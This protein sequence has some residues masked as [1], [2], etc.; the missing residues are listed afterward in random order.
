[1]FI[2]QVAGA[3]MG[4]PNLAFPW[5]RIAHLLCPITIL[6]LSYSSHRHSIAMN[7]GESDY[8]LHD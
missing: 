5:Q 3:V 4:E 7:I 2:A 1:M 6:M 8:G